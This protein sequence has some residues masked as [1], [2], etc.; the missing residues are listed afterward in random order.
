MIFS[1]RPPAWSEL[2]PGP[3]A[4][5]IHGAVLPGTEITGANVQIEPTGRFRGLA[6]LSGKKDRIELTFKKGGKEKKL[7]RRFRIR[8][9]E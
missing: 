3:I 5:E 7:V 4:V 6:F 2:V 9:G 1:T 8:T